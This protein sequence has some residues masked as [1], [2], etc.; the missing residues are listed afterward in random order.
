MKQN[1]SIVVVVLTIFFSFILLSGTVSAQSFSGYKDFRFGMKRNEVI[2]IINR[3]CKGYPFDVNVKYKDIASHYIEGIWCYSILGQH[4]SIHFSFYTDGGRELY[5]IKVG[6]MDRERKRMNE[7]M[8]HFS[9]VRDKI[10][11][12]YRLDRSFTNDVIQR[13]INDEVEIIYEIYNDGRVVLSLEDMRGGLFKQVFV[14]YNNDH[15]A[16]ISVDLAKKY[17]SIKSDDF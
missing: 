5:Q 10:K 2:S 17:N 4:R 14:I 16:K 1:K 9:K 15:L 11:Q 8:N 6:M 3:I 13:W 7:L 12:K